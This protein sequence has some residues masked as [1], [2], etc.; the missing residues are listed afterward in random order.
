[1]FYFKTFPS[2]DNWVPHLAIYGDMGNI[3]ARSLPQLQKEA[4]DGI[5]D[6]VL[7]IGDFAYDMETVRG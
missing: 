4:Q 1:M 6:A 7:H 3:D 2:G 5:Y